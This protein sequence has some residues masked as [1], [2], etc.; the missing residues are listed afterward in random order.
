MVENSKKM[1]FYYKENATIKI[2]IKNNLDNFVN[3]LDEFLKVVEKKYPDVFEKYYN[4]LLHAYKKIS[5][6]YGLSERFLIFSDNFIENFQVKEDSKF[7][8]YSDMLKSSVQAFLSLANINKYEEFSKDEEIEILTTDIIRAQNTFDY[9]QVSLLK[10]IITPEEANEFIREFL[11][12]M[13]ESRR[14]SDNYLENLDAIIER[15]SPG[16]ELWKSQTSQFKK[17]DDGKL[18]LKVSRCA[19]ADVMQEFESDTSFSFICSTDFKNAS[20]LHPNFVLTRTKTLM[21][22]D[23]FCDFCYHDKRISENIEHPSEIE[24][25]KIV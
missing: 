9:Y 17:L 1:N 23:A 25:E 19:W 4:D 12:E 10:E 20:M 14:N 15:F 11:E 16:Y 13:L 21:Q 24:F 2:N 18:I 3:G 7:L 5:T 6:D 22:G 8:K